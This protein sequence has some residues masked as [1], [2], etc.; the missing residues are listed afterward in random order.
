MGNLPF[1]KEILADLRRFAECVEDN[2]DVN[3]ERSRFDL[4]TQLGLLARVQ[5]SPARWMMTQA[6]EDAIALAAAGEPIQVEA[7]AVTR[8]RKNGGLAL[9]WLIEGGISA[10]EAPGVVLLVA[11]GTVTDDQG[12]G[13][14]HLAPPAA[15]HGDEAATLVKAL[16]LLWKTTNF[17]PRG[18][19][20]DGRVS[21]FLAQHAPEPVASAAAMHAQGDEGGRA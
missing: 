11:H 9:E 14:V 21:A 18:G 2:N 5:R 3:L 8:A 10:L 6:G 12:S 16:S 7:V 15:A 4:L 1:V 19:S 20:L 13:E 17:L